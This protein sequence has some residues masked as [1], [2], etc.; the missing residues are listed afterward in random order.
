MIDGMEPAA[1]LFDPAAHEPQAGTR[2]DETRARAGVERIVEAA[3]A[4]YEPGARWPRSPLDE[5]GRPTERDRSLWLGAAGVLW[6]LDRL[7]ARPGEGGLYERYLEAPDVPGSAGLMN[8][9]TGVLLVSWRLAPTEAKAARLFELVEGNAHNPA[10]ELFDGSPG[11]MLA[12]LHLYEQTRDTRWAGLWLRCADALLEQF[13]LDPELG[14]RIWIQHRRGRLIR[15]IGCGHGFASNV[16]SLLRGA[17]LLGEERAAELE[18]AALETVARLALRADG[19][20]NWPTAADPYWAE[21]LPTRVQWCHGAPGLVTSLAGLPRAEA[22]DAL[23]S[24]AGELVWRAGPL[25]KGAGLCHGTAGNGCAF[26]ALHAR[27]GDDLWLERARAFAM[28]ALGQVERAEPRY[29]LW[30]GDVGVALYLRACLEGWQGM[31]IVD[32]L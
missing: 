29:S 6:A 28:H 1:S 12:A 31:P 11:T 19:L 17:E 8:G 2:W 24:A 27:T 22:T 14:C 5:Y 26:L 3:L 30:T 18:R 10:H 7:G 21:Q 32:V 23:L 25:R 20:V 15:S 16:R 9:E 4:G 13:R